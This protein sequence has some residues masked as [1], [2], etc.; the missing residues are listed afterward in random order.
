[1]RVTHSTA[2]VCLAVFAVLLGAGALD[3]VGVAVDDAK[4]RSDKERLKGT[5]KIVSS[6]ADGLDQ[7]APPELR[8]TFDEKDF[9]F[10]HGGENRHRGTFTLDDSASPKTI[11]LAFTEGPHAGDRILGIYAWE[12]DNLKLCITGPNGADR[13]K[14][15]APTLGSGFRLFVLAREQP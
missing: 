11:D 8:L 10:G 2:G 3:S 15:F 6:A 12:G 14:D 13:P 5:W 4:E 9:G 7:P 1:M